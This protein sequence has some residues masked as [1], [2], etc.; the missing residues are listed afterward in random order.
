[1]NDKKLFKGCYTA[2]ITPF[3]NDYKV[4][5]EGLT[6][7]VEFQISQGVSGILVAGTTGESPT[8]SWSEHED[9]IKTV[10]E[11]A[12]ER[13]TI[14]AGTG[15]NNT[16][17]SLKVTQFAYDLGIKN[18]LLIDP[19]YNGP[20]S[21]EIRKEYIEVIANKFPSV[22]I[23]P[24]IIPG[25]TGTQLLPQDLALSY[26]N[27]PNIN[28]VKEATG[29]F[30]NAELTRKLCGSNFCILSGDDD[31]TVKLIQNDSIKSTGVI[32]VASN[33]VPGAITQLVLKT[34]ED[35]S[36]YIDLEKNASPLFKLVG[37]QTTESTNLGEVLVKSR[38]P[39]PT[40]T[41]MRILGLP[42]GPSRQPLGLVTKQALDF[43]LEQSKLVYE[44]SDLFKPAESFFDIDFQER[45]YSDKHINGLYYDSY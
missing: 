1:M 29:D 9:I 30:D 42:S 13:T 24:Y 38:N 33:L 12:G 7:L 19:Y 40:K 39:V 18:I 26:K 23:I 43:I 28:T 6:Q 25:R 8:L 4:D 27:Y 41:L 11:I 37:V 35:N 15:S 20:S 2:L 44:N 22:T 3:T 34:L 14:I 31:K 32:S 45:L 17:E 21:L 10:Y 16:E 5:Y 36:D